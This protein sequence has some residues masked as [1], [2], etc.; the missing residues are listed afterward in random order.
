MRLAQR[1]F[2]LSDQKQF[3]SVSGDH[4]PI[5]LD[6]LQ[7]RR[8]QAGEPVVHGIHLL[9]WALD[10]LAG[11]QPDLPP[12][13]SIRAV[14]NKFVY[15]NDRAELVLTQQRPS[16]A[17]LS[18]IVDGVLRSK[19]NLE[20]GSVDQDYPGWPAASLELIPFSPAPLSL[21]FEQMASRSGRLPFQMTQ[22]DVAALFPAAA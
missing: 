7:A 11:A 6:A 1:E 22:E 16:G 20:F 8:T 3:A 14:F 10:S 13:R 9:L 2:T 21:S 4:N 12:L 18:I 19:I 17:R 5:H 15:L